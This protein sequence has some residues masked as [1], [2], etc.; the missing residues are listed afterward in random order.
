MALMNKRGSEHNLH[1]WMRKCRHFTGVQNKMC[2]AGV[3]YD[4]VIPIPCI[5]RDDAEVKQA[6]CEKKSCW[7][8][9]EAIGIEKEREESTKKFF[10]ALNAAH[11]DAK[12]KGLRKGAGGKDS[13]PCPVCK[14]GTLHYLVAGYNGH[15]WGQCS[16]EK[17]VS[18]ME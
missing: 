17:C 4:D 12:K 16:T 8:R 1:I 13:L 3:N 14:T 5:G 15:L 2:K 18:W 9:E 7:T 11:E 10:I 6:V